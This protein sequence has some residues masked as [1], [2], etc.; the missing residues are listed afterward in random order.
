MLL[1][2]VYGYYF[3]LSSLRHVNT[4]FN[5]PKYEIMIKSVIKHREKKYIPVDGY[6][7]LDEGQFRYF[8]TFN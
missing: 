7:A 6:S 3:F 8:A 4:W 5:S 2:R 1:L